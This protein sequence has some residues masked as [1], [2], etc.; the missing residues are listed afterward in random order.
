MYIIYFLL[1]IGSLL[2]AIFANISTGAVV[3]LVLLA[4]LFLV[5]GAWMLLSARLESKRRSDRQIISP[6]ELRHFRELAG[7]NKAEKNTGPE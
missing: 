2:T 3:V 7:K 4:L 6:E 5:I 1:S